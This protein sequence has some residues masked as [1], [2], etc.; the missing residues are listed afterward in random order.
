MGDVS[1]VTYLICYYMMSQQYWCIFNDTVCFF[2]CFFFIYLQHGA[3]PLYITCRNGH[4][5]VVEKLIAAKAEVNCQR[6]IVS[7]P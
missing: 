7:Y 3:T 6:S 5:A 4:V 2:F 1:V